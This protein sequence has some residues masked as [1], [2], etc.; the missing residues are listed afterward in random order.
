MAMYPHA[1]TQSY[2]AL[3]CSPYSVFRRPCNNG[4]RDTEY[5]IRKRQPVTMTIVVNFAIP[6]FSKVG[7]FFGYTDLTDLGT[8]QT[9]IG[10]KNEKFT[11]SSF[12]SGFMRLFGGK[13]GRGCMPV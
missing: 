13:V 8:D 10:R 1:V 11:D 6:I 12:N 5:G 9:D 4:I 7:I 3:I 2:R